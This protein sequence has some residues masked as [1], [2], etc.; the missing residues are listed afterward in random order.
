M[1]RG[2]VGHIGRDMLKVGAAALAEVV[3]SVGEESV[4]G[5]LSMAG[6]SK[7]TVCQLNKGGKDVIPAGLIFLKVQ[8]P[9]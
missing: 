4:L 2:H 7:V 1:Q 9:P 3:L 8:N 5:T 6:K